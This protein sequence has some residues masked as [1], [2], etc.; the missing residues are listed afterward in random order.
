[1][2]S[3]ATACYQ[4]GYKGMNRFSRDQL[5]FLRTHWLVSYKRVYAD[6]VQFYWCVM[7]KK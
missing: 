3:K 6:L 5:S 4:L 1:M 2:T 7:L